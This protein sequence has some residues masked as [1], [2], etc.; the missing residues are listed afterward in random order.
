MQNLNDL[1][2]SES[3][4]IFD[5]ASGSIAISNPTGIQILRAICEGKSIEEICEELVREYQE[6]PE[7]IAKDVEDFLIQLRNHGYNHD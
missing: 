4:L 5:P 2:I 6:Q 3:G 7:V 1:A